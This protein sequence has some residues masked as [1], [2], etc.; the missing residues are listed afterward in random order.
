MFKFLR[1]N[2]QQVPEPAA[3]EDETDDEVPV[4]HLEEVLRPLFETIK[5]SVPEDYVGMH[6]LACLMFSL[7]FIVVSSNMTAMFFN[8]FGNCCKPRV[9][10][11]PSLYCTSLRGE[12]SCT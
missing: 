7:A 12:G 1:R 4:D 6:I 8:S 10:A 11:V 2:K 9:L 3:A 5:P